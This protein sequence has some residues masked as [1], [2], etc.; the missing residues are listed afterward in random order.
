M[1]EPTIEQR[2]VF[3]PFVDVFNAAIKWHLAYLKANNSPEHYE[4]QTLLT[5]ACKKALNDLAQNAIEAY[6]STLP[7]QQKEPNP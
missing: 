6:L 1:S 2:K 7:N 4:L 5:D 3:Q